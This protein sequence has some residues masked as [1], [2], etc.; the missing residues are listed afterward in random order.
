[1]RVKILTITSQFRPPSFR[2]AEVVAEFERE[3]LS[4]IC[5]SPA[6]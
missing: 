2:I 6:R 5:W 4:D 3:C 1:M